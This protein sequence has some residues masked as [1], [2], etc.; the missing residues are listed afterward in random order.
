MV[1]LQDLC[2]GAFLLLSVWLAD[3]LGSGPQTGL[4]FV[5]PPVSL[6]A[7]GMK[8]SANQGV[9]QDLSCCRACL[10][11][12][13][14]RDSERQRSAM[15]R[16]PECKGPEGTPSRLSR[17]H[18]VLVCGSGQTSARVLS[19]FS[20]SNIFLCS[21]QMPPCRPLRES[22][23]PEVKSPCCPCEIVTVAFR[24][25]RGGEQSQAVAL[26]GP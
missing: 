26:V 9:R 5:P 17:P 15:A 19:L 21:T 25:E 8:D 14:W 7:L 11:V 1:S 20:T 6:W 3:P 23:P 16:A 10:Q 24:G 22:P 13:L 2:S 18:V 12:S 4:V